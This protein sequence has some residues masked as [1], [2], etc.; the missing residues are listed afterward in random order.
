MVAD[1]RNHLRAVDE[2]VEHIFRVCRLPGVEVR[3]SCFFREGHLGVGRAVGGG[4]VYNC[5]AE[6]LGP[7]VADAKQFEE[8]GAANSLVLPN[9]CE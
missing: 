8:Q 3:R 5:A 4:A 9:S 2:Q 1:A 6:R 7:G